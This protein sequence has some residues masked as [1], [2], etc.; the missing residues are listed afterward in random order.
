MFDEFRLFALVC[1]SKGWCFHVFR[2][3]FIVNEISGGKWFTLGYV[4]NSGISQTQCQRAIPRWLFRK[5]I[6]FEYPQL[7]GQSVACWSPVGLRCHLW[8]YQWL[9]RW[10]CFAAE[11]AHGWLGNL[12]ATWSRRNSATK[13]GKTFRG[14]LNGP[15]WL[16]W[17]LNWLNLG[18]IR[19]HMGGTE[20]RMNYRG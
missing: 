17:R 19:Y 8:V 13:R 4:K 10:T 15:R 9:A 12:R 18:Y 11:V 5:L 1:V 16:F 7:R 6:N 2:I 3:C 14:N 20:K